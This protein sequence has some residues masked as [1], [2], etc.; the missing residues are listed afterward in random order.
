MNITLKITSV[1]VLEHGY[2]QNLFFFFY[3]ELWE[4]RLRRW[5]KK[6]K[7]LL[8]ENETGSAK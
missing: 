5:L 2:L 8:H 6:V 4:K 7:K 1:Y 3:I